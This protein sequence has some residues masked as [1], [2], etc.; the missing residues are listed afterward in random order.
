MDSKKFEKFTIETVKRSSIRLATYNPRSITPEA[1]K[2]LQDNIK[3]V[4]LLDPIIWNKR[5]GNVVSGHQRLQCMDVL[6]GKKED[7]EITV[8]AVDLDEKTEKEQ[9]IFMNNPFAMGEYDQ[10]LLPDMLKELTIENTGFDA[11]S[12]HRGFGED[13]LSDKPEL[14]MEMSKKIDTFSEAMNSMRTKTN[15]RDND[16]NFYLVVVFK[17]YDERF[18][19]TE[20]LGLDDDMFVSPDALEDRIKNPKP[21]P[22]PLDLLDTA[23]AETFAP[24]IVFAPD[25][26]TEKEKPQAK[27]GALSMEDAF[28]LLREPL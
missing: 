10:L 22:K 24:E 16:T 20:R 28:D 27:T 2:L 3:C 23:L 11:A 12:I 15:A 14:L 13:I 25:I 4:G 9:N 6:N 21:I 19:F 17:N 8:S 26:V 1:R 7:Y 5:T 18:K